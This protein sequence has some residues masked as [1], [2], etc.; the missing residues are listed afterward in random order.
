MSR[1]ELFEQAVESE[2]GLRRKHPLVWW[3]TLVAPFVLTAGL[4]AILYVAY[5]HGYVHS[6][7]VTGAATVF[8]AGRFM[9]LGGSTDGFFSPWELSFLVLYMDL[10]VALLV[11]YHIG[12]LFKLPWL[13]R[14][15]A[16]LAMQSRRGLA[17]HRWIRRITF[18]VTV[19]FV[20]FPLA[21]TG[22][23]GGG[24]LARLCGISRTGALMAIVLGSILGCAAMFAGAEL[25]RRYLDPTSPATIGAGIA[26]IVV[27]ILVLNWLYRRA[28]RA[29]GP[30]A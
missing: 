11:V 29:T 20:M 2:L 10:M 21:S 16:L 28:V 26:V 8:L 1:D 9:I 7:L 27:V 14:R 4:L 25:I 5:G 22:S 3:S 6:L 19:A 24:I 15:L 30:A 17:R 13:G 23:V 18:L 12:F